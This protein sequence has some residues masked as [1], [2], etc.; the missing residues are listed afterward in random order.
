MSKGKESL[1]ASPS[2]KGIEK[3][4]CE[5]ASS[6]LVE[7]ESTKEVCKLIKFSWRRPAVHGKPWKKVFAVDDEAADSDEAFLDT[8]SS[9]A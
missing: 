6:E 1:L 3:L 8:P 4:V 7:K 2:P 5:L 9:S